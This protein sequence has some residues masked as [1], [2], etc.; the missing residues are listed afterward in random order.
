MSETA[1]SL[2]AIRRTELE[3]AQ[4]I[5]QAKARAEEIV[6]EAKTRARAVVEEGRQRGRNSAQARYEEA[7]A[8]IEDEAATIRQE[9]AAQAAGLRSVASARIDELI[10]EM[11]EVVL[12]PPLERGK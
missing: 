9:G 2:E 3:A 8:R 12:A 4:R 6:T 7:L 5:E 10:A 11:V 1:R